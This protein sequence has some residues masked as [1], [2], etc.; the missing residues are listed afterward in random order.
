MIL[1][2]SKYVSL[3]Y[4]VPLHVHSWRLATLSFL[5]FIMVCIFS[6]YI[7][8]SS[9]NHLHTPLMLAIFH[10]LVSQSFNAKFT[11]L[12]FLEISVVFMILS[13]KNLSCFVFCKI[14]IIHILSLGDNHP[15]VESN[16]CCVNS[17][18]IWINYPA[19]TAYIAWQT[20]L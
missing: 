10:V 9:A 12:S 17:L 1:F 20:F 5:A 16:L 18:H 4:H 6:I 13:L 14:L 15:S 2:S 3:I 7:N 8:P 19:F 11:K